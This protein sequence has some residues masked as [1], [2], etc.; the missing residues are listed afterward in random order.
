MAKISPD[1]E[2]VI[3]AKAGEGLPIRAIA[4]WLLSEHKVKIAPSAVAKRLAKIRDE[5]SEVTKAVVAIKLAG[6]VTADLDILARELRRLGIG[7][8][9]LY[10]TAMALSGNMVD[11][12][13]WELYLK[14]SDRISKL[15][16]M[17]M[18]YAGAEENKGPSS[19]V[20]LPSDPAARASVLRALAEREESKG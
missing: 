2:Q 15:V 3:L 9:R 12:A 19:D 8:G 14:S 20:Q 10:R 5:R 18:K 1:L 13:S 16:E 11:E 4:A 7:A 6:H 17:R